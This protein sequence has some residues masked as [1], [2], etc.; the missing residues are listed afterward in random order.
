MSTDETKIAVMQK[1][2]SYIKEK[3]DEVVSKLDKAIFENSERADRLQK[4]I[5]T[6]FTGVYLQ[7][8]KKADQTEVD[9]INTNLSRVVWV[10]ILAFLASLLSLIII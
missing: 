6:R 3:S 2:I 10:I 7:M 1:E 4:E 5:D 8:E 9:K